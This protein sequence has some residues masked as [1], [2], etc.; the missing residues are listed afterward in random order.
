M[1]AMDTAMLQPQTCTYRAVL[2]SARSYFDLEQMA[3]VNDPRFLDRGFRDFGVILLALFRCAAAAGDKCLT[4]SDAE[5]FCNNREAMNDVH[6]CISHQLDEGAD[7]TRRSLFEMALDLNLVDPHTKEL[8]HP[9]S[10]G[11]IGWRNFVGKA[12]R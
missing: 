10:F 3:M 4:D 7:L 9:E 6:F 5:R 1:P 12:M 2:A 8:L 11:A